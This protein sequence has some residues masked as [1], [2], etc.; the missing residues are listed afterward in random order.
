MSGEVIC[1]VTVLTGPVL[2]KLRKI[3][4]YTYS[5]LIGVV[6]FLQLYVATVL[7]CFFVSNFS[8]FGNS[9]L[10]FFYE[11]HIFNFFLQY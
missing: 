3:K 10:V 2:F 1:V 7:R 11:R 6:L 4:V 5:L 8:F 9:S